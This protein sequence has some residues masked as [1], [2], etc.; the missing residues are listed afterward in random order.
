MG[1]IYGSKCICICMCIYICIL[2]NIYMHHCC[3]TSIWQTF[4]NISFLSK[5]PYKKQNCQTNMCCEISQKSQDTNFVWHICGWADFWEFWPA[6][7]FQTSQDTNFVWYIFGIGWLQLVGSFKSQVSFTKEPYKRD[8]ILQK[9]PMILRNLL[10][11]ATPYIRGEWADIW[12]SQ[13]A[14]H[15]QTSAHSHIPNAQKFHALCDEIH[16]L[17]QNAFLVTGENFHRIRVFGN[18]IFG[19]GIFVFVMDLLCM[20]VLLLYEHSCH[21]QIQK[22]VRLC[23]FVCFFAF[24]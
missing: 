16:I 12:E 19:M 1:N 15:S 20:G 6:T 10:I 23:I 7:H 18:C 2:I 22:C 13:F 24:L 21:S 14:T 17:W 3:S 8:C 5:T 11:V 9:R 4:S